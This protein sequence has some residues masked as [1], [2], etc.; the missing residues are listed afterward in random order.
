M[1]VPLNKIKK[2]KDAPN[3]TV[4]TTFIPRPIK[5]EPESDIE[6]KSKF[7]KP[8]TVSKTMNNSQKS[9]M[10]VKP[11]KRKRESSIS[12]HLD[13]LV[14]DILNTSN[15]DRKSKKSKPNE[16][17]DE[18]SVDLSTTTFQSPSLS[19]TLKP[20]SKS[21]QKSKSFFNKLN[22]PSLP[23]PSIIKQE[24]QSEDEFG[25]LKKNKQSLDNSKSLKSIQNDLFD[26]FLK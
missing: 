18:A 7:K 2:E 22:D 16:S 11:L 19:S 12:E 25:K 3:A 15:T 14:D 20:S 6:G 17:I 26:S 21:K 10:S 1:P 5:V 23:S 24:P 9:E 13:S 4:T 8:T